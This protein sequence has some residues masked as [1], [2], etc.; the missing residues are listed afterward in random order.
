MCSAFIA[1]NH[2]IERRYDRRNPYGNY[3]TQSV[4]N[5]GTDYWDRMPRSCGW[6]DTYFDKIPSDNEKGF[7]L[8]MERAIIPIAHPVATNGDPGALPRG[9]AILE[10]LNEATR[11]LTWHEIADAIQVN[12]ST[13]HRLIK[14]MHELG[15]VCR[16]Q[17]KLDEDF[18]GISAMRGVDHLRARAAGCL[19]F[20]GASD[21]QRAAHRADRPALR[22]RANLFSFGSPPP[23]TVKKPVLAAWLSGTT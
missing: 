14:T 5:D 10:L 7:R 22:E 18:V 21:R 3:G 2:G 12:D 11:R 4:A 20:D 17:A 8:R 23:G 6:H 13:V 16:D 9:I 15:Y 1:W 19:L